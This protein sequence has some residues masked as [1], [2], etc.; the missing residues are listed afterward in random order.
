MPR[1]HNFSREEEMS[2]LIVVVFLLVAGQSLAEDKKLEQF[3]WNLDN[4]KEVGGHVLQVV[5]E[6]RV[7]ET[8]NG[9]KALEFDGVDDGIFLPVHPLAG[10]DVFTVEVIF[11]PY[12]NGLKEQRFFHMQEANSSERVMFETRLTDDDRW[13]IDTFIQSGEGNHVQ[14]AKEFIHPIGPWY[15]AAIVM[16]GKNFTHYVNGKK[17]M[18]TTLEWAPQEP[19]QTSLG[20]RQ[21]KVYWYKGAIRAARFTHG[22][23]SPEEFLK[24]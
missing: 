3:V 21:N 12:P 24:P 1:T 19:G 18:A 13:Y 6:P 7:V 10:W 17:E 20:V 9:G 14:L 8:A 4:T 2:Y 15:H 22:V 5:G 23:L 11:Q 16:D